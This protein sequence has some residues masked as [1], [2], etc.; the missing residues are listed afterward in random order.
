MNKYLERHTQHGRHIYFNYANSKTKV[1]SRIKNKARQLFILSGEIMLKLPHQHS[2]AIQRQFALTG[3]QNTTDFL[4]SYRYFI[5][6]CVFF[7]SCDIRQ[8]LSQENVLGNYST[9]TWR[10]TG[11]A[12]WET[13][14]EISVYED[15][16]RRLGLAQEQAEERQ[17]QTGT[18]R[19]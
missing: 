10:R 5:Y 11:L 18:G 1:L 15:S 19:N 8:Q 17:Q 16:K 9:L 12:R 4:H 7:L 6:K 14:R 2:G 3:P 13:C